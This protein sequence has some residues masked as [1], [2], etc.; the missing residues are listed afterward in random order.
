MSAPP[1]KL[2]SLWLETADRAPAPQLSE[3]VHVDVCV[4]GAGITGLSAAFEAVRSGASVAVL[5][6]RFVGAGASGYNTAKL[7]SLHGLTYSRLES[8]LGAESARLYAG[9]NER[10][11]D[12]VFELVEELGIECDLRRKPNLVYSESSDERGELEAEVQA[13]RRAGLPATFAGGT[14]LP[15][16]IGGAVR[17]AEQAEFHP[18]RYLYGLA[19]ALEERGVRFHE[20]RRPPPWTRA[21]PAG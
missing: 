7:S 20:E 15:Y 3:D 2:A 18:V 12:R 10:G 1:A 19:G 13:A 14:D 5:E 4:V 11:I 16:P 17:L 6:S 21:R 9:A 8:S